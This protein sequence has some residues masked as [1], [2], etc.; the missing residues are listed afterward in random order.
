MIQENDIKTN[1]SEIYWC[2]PKDTLDV[3]YELEKAKIS[4]GKE[5]GKELA[6]FDELLDG[7]LRIPECKKIKRAS[8]LLFGGPPGSGK[9]TL[10]QQLAYKLMKRKMHVLY[11]TTESSEEWLQQKVKSYGWDLTEKELHR[12]NDEEKGQPEFPHIHI[13]ETNLFGYYLSDEN[14]PKKAKQFF[15]AIDGLLK[16]GKALKTIANL[17]V[18]AGQK[19]AVNSLIENEMPEVLILDSLNVIEPDRR[20]ELF[21]KF[22]Q[23]TH[24]GPKLIITVLDSSTHSSGD[25]DYWAYLCDTIIKLDKKIIKNYLVR[26]IEVVK[27]RYQSHIWGSH[28]LKI[29]GTS[30]FD[31][32]NATDKKT[33]L[34]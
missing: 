18:T 28:Q 7:S 9:S 27:A 33:S 14:V 30:N 2:K 13:L 26:T 25:S 1:I 24:L 34:S 17:T 11:V 19:K 16:T 23:L 12:P 29:Y 8:T 6:W 15:E 20:S 3:D 4:F 21:N 5:E 32:M 22:L 31:E 10:A